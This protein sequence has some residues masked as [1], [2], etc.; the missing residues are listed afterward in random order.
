[1]RDKGG[2]KR[3]TGAHKGVSKNC[4]KQFKIDGVQAVP[5]FHPRLGR[6]CTMV[7]SS[8]YLLTLYY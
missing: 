8:Q 5:S 3:E 7:P 6:P 2:S 1:M 4:S